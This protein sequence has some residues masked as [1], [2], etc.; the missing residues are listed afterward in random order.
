MNA[1]RVYGAIL[2]FI[3][4]LSYLYKKQQ[5]LPV[6]ALIDYSPEGSPFSCK[7]DVDII[8]LFKA[9]VPQVLVDSCPSRHP[10][11]MEQHKLLFEVVILS[12]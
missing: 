10:A 7:H 12:T 8:S 6:P 2:L 5:R 1:T 4:Y 11:D 3:I 9:F